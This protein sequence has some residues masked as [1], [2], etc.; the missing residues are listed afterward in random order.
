MR[1]NLKSFT[2]YNYHFIISTLLLLDA[3]LLAARRAGW[4]DLSSA[5]LRLL[6]N[7]RAVAHLLAPN[8][9]LNAIRLAGHDRLQLEEPMADFGHSI[10]TNLEST[11]GTNFKH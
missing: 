8:R 3:P 4:P 5:S 9:R 10:G 11:S 1:T 2:E 6:R 7:L